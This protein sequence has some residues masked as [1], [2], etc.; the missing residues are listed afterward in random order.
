MRAALRRLFTRAEDVDDM[1]AAL[2]AFEDCEATRC[3][4]QGLVAA[5]PVDEAA[6]YKKGY[7]LLVALGQRTPKMVKPIFERYLRDAT[8][9]RCHTAC[10]VLEKVKV[11]CDVDLLSPLLS[12]ARILAWT[13]AAKPGSRQPMRVCDEAAST[14]SQNHP[15]LKFTMAG[16]YTDLDKQIEAMQKQLMQKK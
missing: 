15:D 6:P 7:R 12:D 16:E 4:L 2:P 13:Y 14:L 3:R 11:S 10:L 9:Q 5:L 1:L 8:P